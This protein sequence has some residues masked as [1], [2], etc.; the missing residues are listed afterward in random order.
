MASRH[1]RLAPPAI[2]DLGLLCFELVPII[3]IAPERTCHRIRTHRCRTPSIGIRRLI[4]EINVANRLWGAHR[5][6]GELIRLGIDIGQTSV[7]KYVA[8]RRGPPSQGWKTFLYRGDGPVCRPDPVLSTVDSVSDH[9]R[10]PAP[11][12]VDRRDRSSHRGM[13]CQPVDGCLW[14][15]ASPTPSDLRSGCLL[16]QYIHPLRS[17][18]WHSRSSHISPFAVAE[19][20]R[21][22]LTRL[23]PPGMP[24]LCRGDRRA[25]PSAYPCVPG[26]K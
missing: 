23:D 13:D 6:H 22:A 8:R 24:G 1:L 18:A 2:A 7:A 12:L 16:L 20:I 9:G 17:L 4:R 21:G 15:G 14:L 3:S 26:Q 19:R 5:I 25:A 11:N 10:R